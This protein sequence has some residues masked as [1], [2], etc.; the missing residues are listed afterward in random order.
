MTGGLWWGLLIALY[1]A[2]AATRDPRLFLFALMLT[3]AGAASAL[4]ARYSLAQLRYGRHLSGNR[5]FPGEEADLTVELYNAK[6]L[7]LPWVATS[8]EFPDELTLLTGALGDSRT[9]AHR[10]AITNFLAM[11]WYERVR[12][13][14]RVRGDHR[15]AYQFGPVELYAGD[16]FGFRRRHQTVPQVDE[17]L[18]YPK[19][20]PV[21]GLVLPAARPSGEMATALRVVEDPL[22]YQGVRQYQP[23][24]SYRHIHWKATARTGALQ[25]RTFDPGA[26]HL[27]MLMV[28]VQ[29]TQRAYSMVPDYLE[30]LISAAA[31][32]GSDCLQRGY[33]VGFVA[34]GGPA[35]SPDWAYLPPGRH[36]GQ[37]VQ[38]LEALARLTAF[39]LKP[40][41]QLAA[42]VGM[43]LPFGASVIALSA[44]PGEETQEALLSLQD[45]GHPVLLLTA[46]DQEPVVSSQIEHHHL[47]G[48][49]A[50]Q[51]LAEL[52]FS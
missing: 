7:P 24:D 8:D 40:F 27:L 42:A 45:A 23:G 43:S 38:L 28:D 39:R 9:T 48:S 4:W 26:S 51:N 11:R 25:T 37:V 50:W 31:S 47:G 29:T 1:L 35:H 30:L 32:I 22:R 13:T 33:G 34:N 44:W 52:I 17:L 2:A 46:G 19:V 21:E 12:R 3:A 14:Y 36:P 15:G 16:L 18:V 49:D 5:L 41:P 10:R 6:P 20:V